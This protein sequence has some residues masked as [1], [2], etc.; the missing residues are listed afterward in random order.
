[1]IDGDDVDDAIMLSLFTPGW[2]GAAFVVLALVFWFVA[3]R[4]AD[5]CAQK[6]C[7]LGKPKLVEHECLCVERAGEAVR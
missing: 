4:N 6:A 7:S 1:M 3:S 5:E 2:M